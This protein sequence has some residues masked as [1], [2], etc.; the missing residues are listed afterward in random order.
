MVEI[1]AVENNSL[2]KVIENLA[3]RV[4]ACVTFERF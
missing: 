2:H 3:R 1:V 4:I